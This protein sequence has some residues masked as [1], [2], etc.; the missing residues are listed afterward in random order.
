MQSF[1]Q[2][3]MMKFNRPRYLTEQSTACGLHTVQVYNE[4]RHEVLNKIYDG[5][6]VKCLFAEPDLLPSE[7]QKTFQ[8]DCLKFYESSVSYLQSQLPFGNSFL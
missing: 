1:L 7:K 8:E 6:K 3:L 2:N 5:T 4:K